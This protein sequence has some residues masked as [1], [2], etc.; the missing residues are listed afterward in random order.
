[1][2]GRHIEVSALTHHP[3][4]ITA[5]GLRWYFFFPFSY[6]TSFHL[7]YIGDFFCA[8]PVLNSLEI[9]MI[10]LLLGTVHLLYLCFP[11]CQDV[12]LL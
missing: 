7:I 10:Y 4:S 9:Y 8:W 3:I 11:I 1:M 6:F 2:I 12:K 5:R